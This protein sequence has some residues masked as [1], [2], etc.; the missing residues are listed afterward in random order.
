V[1]QGPGTLVYDGDC[2][3]CTTSA[4]WIV[5]HWPEG[6]GSVATPWQ[7]LAPDVVD[8]SR[9]SQADFQRAAWWIEGDRRQEGS[10]AVAAALIAAGGWLRIAGRILL[11]PPVSWV[12]PLGYRIVAKYRYRLPGGTPACKV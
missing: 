4:N 8:K 3:F 1:R 6:E 9:L 7:F 11:L 2:G 10:L 5:R 12:A